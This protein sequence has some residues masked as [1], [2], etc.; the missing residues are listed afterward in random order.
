MFD[1]ILLTDISEESVIANLTTL[2]DNDI[3]YVRSIHSIL[4]WLD[5]AANLKGALF[6]SDLTLIRCAK[7]QQQRERAITHSLGGRSMILCSQT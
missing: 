6:S 4:G 1:A 7:H 2:M 3:I 5:S